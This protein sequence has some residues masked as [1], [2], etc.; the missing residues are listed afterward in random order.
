M[1]LLY[2]RTADEQTQSDISQL[3]AKLE[4]LRQTELTVIVVAMRDDQA[5]QLFATIEDAAEDAAEAQTRHKLRRLL[6]DPSGKGFGLDLAS[7]CSC[8]KRNPG[9]W[10]P[11]GGGKSILSILNEIKDG[12]TPLEGWRLPKI[13]PIDGSQLIFA[14]EAQPSKL[15]TALSGR[16]CLLIIDAVSLLHPAISAAL[17]EAP[18]T[19][20]PRMAMV[21]LTPHGGY[22]TALR[23]LHELLMGEVAEAIPPQLASFTDPAQILLEFGIVDDLT[24]RRRIRTIMPHLMRSDLGL[25]ATMERAHEGRASKGLSKAV[26]G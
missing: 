16:I 24:L 15:A 5:A 17:R 7:L 26:F 25:Q 11:F 22:L 8:Y 2:S 4:L 18:L 12:L 6:A 3:Q 21:V 10:E 19:K 14:P 1:T 9:E 13:T 23:R 20:V